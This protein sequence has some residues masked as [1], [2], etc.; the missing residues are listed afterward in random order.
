M[1]LTPFCSQSLEDSRWIAVLVT[2]VLISR[3][4]AEGCRLIL[5]EQ[6]EELGME[7]GN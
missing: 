7:Q 5:T 2:S 6:E 3:E 4:R 1:G